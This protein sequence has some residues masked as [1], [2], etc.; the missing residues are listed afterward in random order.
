MAKNEKNVVSRFDVIQSSNHE[1]RAKKT[2]RQ[3]RAR[4][5]SFYNM[6]CSFLNLVVVFRVFK[7]HSTTRLVPQTYNV[8][9][10]ITMIE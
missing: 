5:A 10:N 6:I 8:A 3:L 2:L 4:Y 9:S 1:W 7:D